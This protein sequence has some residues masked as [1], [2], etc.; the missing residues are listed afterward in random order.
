M[1]QPRALAARMLSKSTALDRRRLM[2][3]QV[4]AQ[5]APPTLRADRIAAARNV[6]ARP[7][8]LLACCWNE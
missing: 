7:T 1:S 8:A 2:A 4:S 5:S 3:D 6:S